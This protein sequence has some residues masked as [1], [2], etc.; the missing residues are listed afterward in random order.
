MSPALCVIAVFGALLVGCTIV[1][2]AI[3][4]PCP[5][6]EDDAGKKYYIL[7]K[8]AVKNGYILELID[9]RE[10]RR[11][12]KSYGTDFFVPKKLGDQLHTGETH[13]LKKS[14]VRGLYFERVA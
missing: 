3:I 12:E 1:H 4:S 7:Y 11:D 5:L 6:R 9:P 10:L 8:S 13:K 2:K 14:S